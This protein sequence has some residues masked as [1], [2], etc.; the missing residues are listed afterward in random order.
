MRARN[1]PGVVLTLL[2]RRMR[3]AAFTAIGELD[4]GGK[5]DRDFNLAGAMTLTSTVPCEPEPTFN[6]DMMLRSAEQSPLAS[7][8]PAGRRS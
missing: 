1:W 6:E 3:P 2:R 8:L 4:A 7:T 5:G